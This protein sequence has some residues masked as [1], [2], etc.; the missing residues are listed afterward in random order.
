MA[1]QDLDHSTGFRVLEDLAFHAGSVCLLVIDAQGSVLEINGAASRALKPLALG[2]R[3]WD[4]LPGSGSD[5]LRER[6]K[7]AHTA[8]VRGFHL[9]F[10][11]GETYALTLSCSIGWTGESYFLLGG[12]LVETD[13]RMKQELLDLTT[14]LV[15]SNRER[16]KVAGEL[17]SALVELENSHWHIRRI[18]EFLPA[19]CVCKKIR[20]T[21]ADEEAV[22][23]SLSSFLAQ[24]G[25]LMSHGYCPGCEARVLAEIDVEFPVP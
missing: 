4:I 13:Q 3:V 18:Q 25:L 15:A 7:E 23:L 11:D 9:N 24:N 20:P 22:W 16:T 14:E 6:M 5:V 10:S 21:S 17:K 19:C 1:S 8:P 12:V 2:G